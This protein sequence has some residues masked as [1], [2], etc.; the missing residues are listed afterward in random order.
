MVIAVIKSTEVV[1]LCKMQNTAWCM[2]EKYNPRNVFM[3]SYLLKAIL[4]TS[5]VCVCALPLC[6][7]VIR[8]ETE[9]EKSIE[10]ENVQPG[11][12]LLRD[13]QVHSETA[14]NVRTCAMRMKRRWEGMTC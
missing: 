9:R 14:P 4:C 12:K 5:Y 11:K 1:F 6:M 2:L 8:R 13:E 7:C 10:G 3:L